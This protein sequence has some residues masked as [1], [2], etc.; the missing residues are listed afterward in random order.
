MGEPLKEQWTAQE[1]DR[2]DRL[3]RLADAIVEEQNTLGTEMAQGGDKA[4]TELDWALGVAV[5][6]IYA[7]RDRLLEMARQRARAS[8]QG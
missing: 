4:L 1:A 7:E 2:F 5:Q 8:E 6:A 3:F